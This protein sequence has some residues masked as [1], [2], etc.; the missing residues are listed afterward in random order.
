LPGTYAVEVSCQ[1]S[2]SRATYPPLIVASGDV[3]ME[4][5]VDPGA[6]IV[7][8]VRNA[9]GAPVGDVT[10]ILSKNQTI[11]E[12]WWRPRFMQTDRDGR[13]EI[14]GLPGG[15]FA[16]RARATDIFE[17]GGGGEDV[18][19]AVNAVVERN[20]VV[21]DTGAVSGKVVD[22]DGRPLG[23]IS[24]TLDRGAQD[25][26]AD[27]SRSTDA[28]G[29]F[30]IDRLRPGDYFVNAQRSW[31]YDSKSA[32]ERVTV[33]ANEKST[34]TITIAENTGAISGVVTD[35]DGT[36]AVDAFVSV[37]KYS[38]G[39]RLEKY[40]QTAN[41]PIMTTVDGTFIASK[42]PLGN[43]YTIRAFRKGGGDGVVEN[44]AIGGSARIQLAKLGSIAGTVRSWNTALDELSISV[45][46]KQ[47]AGRSEHF[48]RTNGAFVIED[49][50]A[51]HYTINAGSEG[52][53]GSA[54]V[55][56]ASGE[57]K[58]GVLIELVSLVT[59][60]GR[61][62]DLATKQPI[63]KANV[64]ARAIGGETRFA[65]AFDPND[66]S[67]ISDA[68]GRFTIKRVPLGKVVLMP[69]GGGYEQVFS[70]RKIAGTSVVDIGDIPMVAAST[71]NAGES[72]LAFVDDYDFG[73][74][75][76]AQLVVKSVKPSSPGALAGIKV[77][78]IITSVNGID[79]TGYGTM[80]SYALF[81]VAAAGTK[82]SITLA[83]GISVNI[84]LAPRE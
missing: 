53:A 56:L 37:E 47:I 71:G 3:A 24:L 59:V 23:N 45:D 65:L 50:P 46:G 67:Y 39:A 22:G 61:V 12:K 33:R 17:Y 13:Y 41:G 51:G 21:E 7:G 78:D 82:L 68:N 66:R 14:A 72:G 43:T 30:A 11:D 40:D 36:P 1:G 10:M 16:L 31:A 27:V 44:V 18:V 69:R 34:L 19:V 20:F 5:E 81:H 70:V 55:E 76:R 42:L 35:A 57:R 62:V 49:L 15:T 28:S 74:L 8:R 84:T 80:N 83:R 26:P 73:Q 4:L 9:A 6:K 63:A 58:T 60:T 48:F 38:A 2:L 52:K 25:M 64:E 75:D 32:R 29:N 77:G 54:V 79:T